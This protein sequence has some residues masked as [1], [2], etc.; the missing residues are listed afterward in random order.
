MNKPRNAV[1]VVYL[2]EMKSI[3][4]DKRMIMAMIAPIFIMP[5]V[6]VIV[7]LLA[8]SFFSRPVTIGVNN[9]NNPIVAALQ[10]QRP[11]SEFVETT[12]FQQE[13]ENGTIAI[14]INVPDD[15]Q[16]KLDA[17]ESI[18][19]EI[20]SEPTNQAST[21]VASDVTYVISKVNENILN[22][23]LI[24]NN[25]NPDITHLVQEQKINITSSGVS[26]GNDVIGGAIAGLISFLPMMLIFAGNGA[27]F[28]IAT[29]LGAAEKERNSFEILLSTKADRVQILTG[30]LLTV[31]SFGLISSLIFVG[32]ILIYTIPIFFFPEVMA[33][34]GSYISLPMVLITCV[35]ILVMSLF[36]STIALTISLIAKSYKEAQTYLGY[37][38]LIFLVPSYI[39]MFSDIRNVPF[40]QL[41]LPFI[42]MIVT[43]KQVMSGIYIWPNILITIAWNLIYV[44]LALILIRRLLTR[45]QFLFRG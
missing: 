26:D 27:T 5:I 34:I 40:W 36:M 29:E 11:N 20:I 10:E 44:V 2:K 17:L 32:G 35:L 45:E 33:V 24:A 9:M 23:Q 15:Y 41:N 3:F 13:I 14:G 37:M 31:I 1:M 12:N 4:R 16:A 30:K 18:T 21:D 7:G 6:I 38:S 43:M 19:V 39:T 42:N 22:Q 8:Y 25:I 28:S